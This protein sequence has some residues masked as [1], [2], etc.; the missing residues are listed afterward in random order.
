MIFPKMDCDDVSIPNVYINKKRKH[1]HKN[2]NSKNKQSKFNNNE[3]HNKCSKR[4]KQKK[5]QQQQ[6]KE[7]FMYSILFALIISIK[8]R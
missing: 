3:K 2:N 4:N 7:L 6:T 5:D 1:K 8:C